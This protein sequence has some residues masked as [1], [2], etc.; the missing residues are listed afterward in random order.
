MKPT[1]I[2]YTNNADLNYLVTNNSNEKN[3]KKEKKEL[4]PVFDEILN[5]F[6]SIYGGC[7][8]GGWDF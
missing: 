8:K 6:Q 5:S 2:D 1:V 7:R 3:E 4:H